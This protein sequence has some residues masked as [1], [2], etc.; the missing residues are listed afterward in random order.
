VDQALMNG[1]LDA[2][3]KVPEIQQV[4]LAYLGD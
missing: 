2:L 3:A 4:R 1:V